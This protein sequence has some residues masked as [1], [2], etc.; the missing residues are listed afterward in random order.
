MS[1]AMKNMQLKKTGVNK[2][3]VTSESEEEVDEIDN[4]ILNMQ[5]KINN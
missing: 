1:N 4:Q 3:V 2:G 5:A